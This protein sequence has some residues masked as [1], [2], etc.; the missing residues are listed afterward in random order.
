MSTLVNNLALLEAAVAEQALSMKKIS[1]YEKL[2]N[3][4]IVSVKQDMQVLDQTISEGALPVEEEV[5]HFECKHSGKN[6]GMYSLIFDVY[7]SY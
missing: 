6:G 7:F 5:T 3:T 1:L 4:H 2:S